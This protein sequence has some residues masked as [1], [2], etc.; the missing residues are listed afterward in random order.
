[1]KKCAIYNCDEIVKV[2]K[3]L[4]SENMIFSVVGD[5]WSPINYQVFEKAAQLQMAGKDV[6][7]VCMGKEQKDI[8]VDD[9]LLPVVSRELIYFN[10]DVDCS[11]ATDCEGILWLQDYA[12][13]KK[14]II[15]LLVMSYC[16][17]QL[18]IG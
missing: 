3:N 8:V 10:A 2:L 4:I 17:V 11:L 15:M 13:A 5:Y 9:V 18:A 16:V 1:M 12:R 6:T 14:C 7:I